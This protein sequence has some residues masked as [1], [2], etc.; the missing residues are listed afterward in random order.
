VG[1]GVGVGMG[2][3]VNVKF[4]VQK[5]IFFITCKEFN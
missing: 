3:R 1:V 4:E 5:Y 2:M